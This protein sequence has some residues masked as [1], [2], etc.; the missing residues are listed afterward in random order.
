[1]WTLSRNTMLDEIHSM[2]R[3]R[4]RW[5]FSHQQ[6][7]LGRAVDHYALYEAIAAR[8]VARIREIIPVHLACARDDA[9]LRVQ[10]MERMRRGGAVGAEGIEA[11]GT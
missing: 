8:D 2:M 9:L 11:A 1:M 10:R 4:M 3:T 5:V 7:I 6:D